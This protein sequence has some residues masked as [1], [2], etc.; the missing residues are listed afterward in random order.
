MPSSV[1]RRV[2]VH[3]T[4]L[5]AMA[6][7]TAPTVRTRSLLSAT[8]VPVKRVIPSSVKRR[9]SVHLT[10]LSAMGTRTVPTVRTR[11]LL[12]VIHANA[13]MR[14]TNLNVNPLV[15]VPLINQGSAMALQIVPTPQTK[16]LPTAHLNHVIKTINSGAR[17]AANV[18]LKKPPATGKMTVGMAQMN[19]TAWLVLIVITATISDVK[20]ANV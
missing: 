18:L 3:L 20:T 2:S 13:R 8:L 19:K 12:S 7:R 16:N 9:V 6:T 14:I 10:D 1:K 11:S 4:D 17:K 5:S 15:A